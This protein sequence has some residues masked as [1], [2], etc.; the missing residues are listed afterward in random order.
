[1]LLEFVTNQVAGLGMVLIFLFLF[2]H[3]TIRVAVLLEFETISNCW[4]WYGNVFFFIFTKLSRV[5]VL[6]EFVTNQVAGLGMK[7]NIL[8]LF[9]HQTI[10]VAVLL[11]F[12][13]ISSCWTWYGNTFFLFVTPLSESPCD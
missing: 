6:L 9:C 5:A 13:T 12:E 3:Q 7:L 1:M 2:S 11:E 8:F 10:R 4:T